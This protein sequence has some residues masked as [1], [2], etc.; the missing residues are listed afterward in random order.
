MD[1]SRNKATYASMPKTAA[2]GAL[3]S[4]ARAPGRKV[5]PTASAAPEPLLLPWAR[6]EPT[7]FG[8]RSFSLGALLLR[9]RIF[10]LERHGSIRLVGRGSSRDIQ[11][12]LH[13]VFK[14]ADF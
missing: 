13:L 9:L 6:Q 1:S 4:F 10:D 5:N 3:E 2:L 11:W 14:G 12:V 7:R 8:E